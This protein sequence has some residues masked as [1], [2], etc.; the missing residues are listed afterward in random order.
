MPKVKISKLSKFGLR[1][2]PTTGTPPY[3]KQFTLAKIEPNKMFKKYQYKQLEA[4][5]ASHVVVFDTSMGMIYPDY[6]DDQVLPVL[7]YH[8]VNVYRYK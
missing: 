1:G 5:N 4:K 7:P 2:K 3:A 8:P 6:K